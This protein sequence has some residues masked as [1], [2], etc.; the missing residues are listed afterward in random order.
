MDNSLPI[1]NH[2]F[3][4]C[5][6]VV[7]SQ[8]YAPQMNPVMATTQQLGIQPDLVSQ[9]NTPPA[10]FSFEHES[11]SSRPTY[12]ALPQDPGC[13]VTNLVDARGDGVALHM[14]SQGENVFIVCR[15][16]CLHLELQQDS[17]AILLTLQRFV[18]TTHT[19]GFSHNYSLGVCIV[20]SCQD[21]LSA[22]ITGVFQRRLSLN[23]FNVAHGLI[24][25]CH[26]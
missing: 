16:S 7:V 25:I 5:A 14:L 4:A 11:G 3:R 9:I 2:A 19:G 1:T 13:C 15:Q 18:C 26:K 10:V 20:A 17:I 23:S 24:H 6:C 22:T 8:K 21:D 12:G